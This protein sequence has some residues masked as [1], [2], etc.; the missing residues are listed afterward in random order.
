MTRTTRGASNRRASKYRTPR[1]SVHSVL[2]VANLPSGKWLEPCAGEGD[3]ILGEQSCTTHARPSSW[4]AIE[5]R[6]R[7]AQRLRN[8]GVQAHCA[9]FFAWAASQGPGSFDVALGNPPFVQAIPFIEECR[10]LAT[11]TA[12]LLPLSF[13]SSLKRK[14]FNQMNPARVLALARR[15]SFYNDNTDAVS[16][17]W[18][19]WGPPNVYPQ[20]T[21]GVI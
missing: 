5:I 1:W 21:H 7:A 12:M 10:R 9:D 14:A 4:T 19:I 20:G 16:Y 8:L 11:V 15:P 3:I 2:S 17:G 13:L 18:F 6:T